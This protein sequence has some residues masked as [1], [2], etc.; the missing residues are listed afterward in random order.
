MTQKLDLILVNPGSRAQVYGKLGS[1]LAGIEPPLWAG[2]IAAFVR[3]HSHSV[4]IIDAEAENWSPEYTAEKIAEYDPL[5]AGIIV[6]GSNPSASSTPKMTAAGE[7]AAALKKKAPQVKILFG[8]LHPSAL[9]E[10]TLREEK[11]D[12]VCQGEGFHTVLQLLDVLKAE[13]APAS[14]QIH[15]LWYCQNGGV[16]ANT[17]APLVNPDELPMAAWDLLPM[18]KYRAHNWHCFDHID[19]R[20]PYAVIY[21]SLGCPF[22]CSYCNIH[23]LYN[24]KPGIRFRS[25]EKVVED[26]DFLVKNYKVRNIKFIDELFAIREDRVTHIC[27]L[28]VKGNYNLNIWAYA[29]VDTVSEGMMK[30]M[31]QAGINWVAYGFESA[32]M[33]VRQGVTKKF[34]QDTIAKAVEMTRAAGIY[35]IGN[36]IFGLPDDDLE[37][38]CETLEMAKEFNF[39]YINF[40]TAMAYPGSPLYEEAIKQGIKL[41]E[42]WHG[43]GQYAEETLPLPTKHLSADNVLHFRD[44][45]FKEYFSNPRY[46][47]MMREKFGPEV[48]EHIEE[49]LKHEIRR[50]ILAP[51]G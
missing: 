34:E 14:Y 20:Q 47:K 43:Y 29:R 5:L 50:K 16:I 3:R 48:V 35:I 40:Y 51:E 6:L 22:N 18:D 11:A 12:F 28:I 31:K 45:A 9:P 30:K 44:N 19:Q 25:P 2:L 1:S 36:F 4:K 46:L 17:P 33:K 27:D 10:Q 26:I 38:M 13:K 7:V 24:D 32:S 21:T 15:G 8:G 37:T 23:A 39:E 49:M 42:E 41:P